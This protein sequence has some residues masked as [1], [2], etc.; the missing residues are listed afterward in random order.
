MGRQENQY[1]A[2]GPQPDVEVA[3]SAPPPNPPSAVQDPPRIEVS[4]DS[5]VAGHEDVCSRRKT[6]MFLYGAFVEYVRK[7][8]RDGEFLVGTPNVRWGRTVQHDGIWI[9]AEYNWKPSNPEFLPAIFVRLG[10]IQYTFR[11]GSQDVWVGSNVRNGIEYGERKGNGTVSFVHVSRSSGE[12]V[13]LCDN[14]RYRINEYSLPIR[15]DLCLCKLHEQQASPLSLSQ[16]ESKEAYQSVTSFSFEFLERWGVKVES[17]I[18]RSVDVVDTGLQ[19]SR[20]YGIIKTG[21]S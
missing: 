20:K 5:D 13:A 10:D 2:F 19:G 8:Y 11:S 9:D 1:G 17:P 6:C 3:P 4:P 18:L 16:K 15:R 21:I 7:L 14:T 12:A